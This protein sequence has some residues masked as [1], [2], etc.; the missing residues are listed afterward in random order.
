MGS[1]NKSQ[2]VGRR[3][4][5][6]IHMGLGLPLDEI[7]QI[8]ASAKT[9]WKG[10]ITSNGQIT[11]SAGN[12]FGGDKGEGGIEGTLDV[13]FGEENQVPVSKLTS[14]LSQ[15]GGVVPAFRG[16]TTAFFS[17][18]VASNNPYPK[19]WEFLRR[20]GNRLW[21]PDSAWYPEKQF[22]WLADNQIKAMNPAHILYLLYTGQRFGKRPRARMDDASW[23]AA[24]DTLYSEGLGLCLEW[25][26]SDTFKSF[27]DTVLGHISAEIYLSRRTGLI[28]IRLLRDDYDV[29]SLPLFDEDSG[30]LEIT[31][32]ESASND[33]SSVPSVLYVKYV[34]AIDGE[35][36][37]VK[38]VNSAVAKRDGG[39]SAQT[40]EY[41]GAPTGDIAGRL[42]QRDMRLKTSGLKRF[43]IVLDRRGRN[44]EPGQPF[45]IRSLRRGIDQIVVRVGRYEDGTLTDGRITITALQD[46][47]SLPLTSFIATPPAGWLP[48][49][50]EPRAITLRRIFE[51][52]YRE[53]AGV[54]DPANLARLDV[55]GALMTA[56]AAAPTSMSLSYSLTDRVGT[57]GAFVDRGEGDWCPTALLT[58]VLPIGA[59]PSVVTLASGDRL[60][61]VFVGQ[62]ALID[63]EIVRVDAINYST[64]VV[65]LARGCI[66]TVPAQ[67]AAGARVW[68]YDNFENADETVYSSGVT[69]QAQLLTNTGVGQLSP[70]LAGTDS[71]TLTGRQGRPYPPGQFKLS[72]SY[73]PAAVSGELILTGVHRDRLQQADQ[74]VDTTVGAIG[75]E[76]GTTY[77]AR[78]VRADT[79]AEL[80]SA[81]GLTTPTVTLA[82]GY[83]GAIIA[84]MW[85]IRGGLASQQRQRHQFTYTPPAV[86]SHRYWRVYVTAGES[87]YVGFAEVQLLKAGVN[88]ATGGTASASSSY[89]GLPPSNAFDGSTSTEW[90]NN[91]GFPAWLAYDFG[92]PKSVDSV[93]L[94]ARSFTGQGPKTFKIQYSDDNSAWTDALTV[95]S[96]PTWG[97]LE[98]RTYTL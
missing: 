15:L 66:D 81:T 51:L 35:S 7:C 21:L 88:Q 62:A 49:D 32:D 89:T 48:P 34:D 69:L 50:R 61:E 28:T 67:H 12:L 23:R 33:S 68:F 1:S 90:A 76:S 31:K 55:T 25:K 72:G 85:S 5:F 45:R 83:A 63:D 73:Y 20:G 80:T 37:Q 82:T 14:M 54:V 13:M 70:G 95:A 59:G 91:S 40:V 9:A 77:S 29:D 10:S 75:P 87:S 79:L 42:L 94:Q 98:A 56:V 71:L 65:T 46:V 96:A 84:E 4:M 74:L 58:A 64:G 6:D 53:L 97:S 38:G 92:T 93:K 18:L 57:S 2:T 36:K 16:V 86:G 8:R 26:R 47:F 19:A 22:I 52:P 3:Y 41:V 44:L 17:G 60:E 11:I 39:Q 27:R 43:K 24:A 30:L 78:L